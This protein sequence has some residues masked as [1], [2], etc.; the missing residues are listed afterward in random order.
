MEQGARTTGAINVVINLPQC[1]VSAFIDRYVITH[2]LSG[3]KSA[4][5]HGICCYVVY[6]PARHFWPKTARNISFCLLF[7]VKIVDAS[8][9]ANLKLRHSINTVEPG[10]VYDVTVRA[11]SDWKHSELFVLK[12]IKVPARRGT[13]QY[14]FMTSCTHKIAHTSLE[15]I[16][17]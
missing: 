2:W 10:Q 4:A 17:R 6:I 7:S 12:E 11:E 16:F 8:G 13:V 14:M 5:K 15:N 1:G 9:A 3:S